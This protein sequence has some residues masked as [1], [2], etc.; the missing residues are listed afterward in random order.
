M[1]LISLQI[2]G[3]KSFANETKIQFAPG[4]TGVVGPNGCGK[5]NVVDALRWVLGEQRSS[6]LRGERMENVIF[7]GTAK[8]K[9]LNLAE[10]Q[11][12]FDNTS[13][14]INLPYG[15]IEITRRLHRD[16][17]S[18]Y[19]INGNACRLRDITDM[20]Q[21]SG[22]GPNA[23]TILELKMIE[24][25]LREEGEGRRQLF[26]EASGI[27]KYKLRRRQALAKLAQTEE[28]LLRLADI[29]SEVER[30]VASLKRQVSR[31][32]R[33]QELTAELKRSEAAF[34]V[35]EYDRLHRE[36]DPMRSALSDAVAHS[37]GSNSYLRQFEARVEQLRSEQMESDQKLSGL[38]QALQETV[39]QISALEADKAGSEARLTSAHD[40][41]DRSQRQIILA[42]DRLASLDPR[43]EALAR[44]K[45]EL[46]LEIEAAQF[47]LNEAEQ[48][49][50]ACQ[51]N[52]KHLE[53]VYK[54]TD[55]K[56][57]ALNKS[58]ANLD[59]ERAK[60]LEGIAR[61][62]GRRD[63]GHQAREQVANERQEMERR[64][65][66]L[67][68]ALEN[69]AAEETRLRATFAAA[70]VR[71]DEMTSS[72]SELDKRLAEVER[73]EHATTSHIRL[74]ETLEQ[75]GPRGTSQLK[76]LREKIQGTRLIADLALVKENYARAIHT[77][78][79]NSAYHVIL[80]SE[81]E[82]RQAI[83][84]L[85]SAD[86]GKCGFKLPYT[87]SQTPNVEAPVRSLGWAADF[88]DMSQD[89]EIVRGLL[90]DCLVVENLAD[91]LA[92]REFLAAH[93]CRAVTLSGDWLNY[94]GLC[95]AGADQQ[96]APS[97][98][99]LTRQ[100]EVLQETLGQAKRDRQDIESLISTARA[101][102]TAWVREVEGHSRAVDQARQAHEK[103]RSEALRAETL[104][105]AM[106]QRDDA[107]VRLIQESENAEHALRD[108]V[109]KQVHSLDE[110]RR[111]VAA[112]Q[113]EIEKMSQEVW[114]AR[115][116][117]G[118]A[119]DAYHERARALDGS[120]HRLQLL[121][122][123]TE[124]IAASETELAESIRQNSESG[125]LAANTIS[126]SETA[127]RGISELLRT[128]F[129]T[130]DERYRVV[131]EAQRGKDAASGEVRN[132]EDQ[133]KK[134]RSSREAA[135]DDQRK[136]EISI[137]KIEGELESLLVNARAQ[138]QIELEG[139]EAA[140][141]LQQL[142][143]IQTGVEVISELR[144]KI[145][146]LGTVNLLAVEEYDRE[147]ERL[148]GMLANRADLLS[149]KSTLEE[150]IRKINETAEAKFLHTFEAVRAN[151]Q[152]LFG[153][154]FPAGEADLILSGKDLLEADI[155]MW[156]NPSGK[157]LKS[158]TLMSGGE[159]T[160]TAIALLFSLYQ[161]KP[162]PFCVLD[163]VDAPLDDAN[164]DRFTRMIHRHSD[165]TQFI[166]ITHNKRTMEIADN[167]YGVTMQEE[168]VSKT[169]SVRL[170]KAASQLAIGA[171]TATA[172]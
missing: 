162:S 24:D 150:T 106:T 144:T 96:N 52:L 121:D 33:Y 158:L 28:D 82:L 91:A 97:D 135:L 5:S 113:I 125:E 105:Q 43:K 2:S 127:L 26:E 117:H 18:E 170:L 134:L 69:A 137:A 142:R 128:L 123:E 165:H 66:E 67:S 35:V 36:L 130:R 152:S 98:L 140:A 73:L 115:Q 87:A 6:V 160:M 108:E 154:F 19:L 8:R 68:V 31:A 76:M 131:D 156:A 84:M 109:E 50:D 139:E 100:I 129:H 42:K 45:N 54:E 83:E 155:T 14:R 168:G 15:E 95:F 132:M 55:A 32:R 13:G 79:G 111:A 27:A 3:F 58:Q 9:P 119:R 126:E 104:S 56:L 101:E 53:T 103:I 161:V 88:V 46:A 90:A 153:E 171:E 23:Y 17:T 85:G 64:Q 30:Q 74:L 34:A 94:D 146:N 62:K 75:R 102:Y 99:G 147:T 172:E 107:A 138:H 169:V 41:L 63:S 70:R 12:R 118:A 141:S 48:K 44:D 133:L 49:Y 38:R 21:D 59:A 122:A 143:E 7:N 81:D 57:A 60:L 25:I 159:K 77:A 166:M 61:Q 145:E 114:Q 47:A 110:N 22:L 65:K 151:F 1:Q 71:Q 16:G 120:K 136:L 164:I 39:S 86:A 29:V 20:L 116:E 124:R 167:L 112:V 149:A 51:A 92:L 10:V 148:D 72:R 11:V 89:S 40:S 157:R 163:E 93:R 80:Q 37:E 78:L 4:V